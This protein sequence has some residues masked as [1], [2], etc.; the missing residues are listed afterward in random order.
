MLLR[1]IVLPQLGLRELNAGAQV[2]FT[3]AAGVLE[4]LVGLPTP[5]EIMALCPSE[6]LQAQI[7]PCWRRTALRI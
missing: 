4:F 6:S 7:N 2:E 3:G 1:A 5:E